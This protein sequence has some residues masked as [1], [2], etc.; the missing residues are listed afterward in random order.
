MSDYILEYRECHR[1]SSGEMTQSQDSVK[2]QLSYEIPVYTS[3]RLYDE[4]SDCG[5]PVV[6]MLSS[7][8]CN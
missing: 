3:V 2:S 4:Q 6:R 8:S 5:R 1:V 7:I